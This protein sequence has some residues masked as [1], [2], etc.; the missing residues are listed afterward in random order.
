MQ[1]TAA[2]QGLSGIRQDRLVR[3]ARHSGGV[4]RLLVTDETKLNIYTSPV[5]YVRFISGD[6]SAT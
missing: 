2:A 6:E 4:A 1:F 3:R 5:S